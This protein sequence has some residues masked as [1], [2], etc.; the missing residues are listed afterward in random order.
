MYIQCLPIFHDNYIWLLVNNEKST[1]VAVD[2]G[3][4]SSLEIFLQNNDLVLTDILLTHHHADHI[5]G[6]EELSKHYQVRVYGPAQEN[7]CGVTNPLYDNQ[8]IF[9]KNIDTYFKVLSIPGHTLGHIAYYN[10]KNHILFCGDTLFSAGC[11]RIFEGT[12]QQMYESL[13]KI[14]KL[15]D[16]TFIYCT[17]EYTLNNLKFAE[18]IEPD[19][20]DIKNK[21]SEI[22]N[23]LEKGQTSLPSK[24]IDERKFNPFLRCNSASLVKNLQ[25]IMQ[26]KFDDDLQIFTCLRKLKDNF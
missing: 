22:R 25:D 1:V 18:S 20:S 6:V 12:A 16:D 17:H 3:D 14:N 23:M 2:P 11:G 5:G 7:I 8:E 9:L 4:S 19:N 13:Q 24:L 26:R 10:S 21:I 15:P